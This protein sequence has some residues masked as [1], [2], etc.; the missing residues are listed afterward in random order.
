MHEGA[1]AA[2]RREGDEDGRTELTDARGDADGDARVR[3]W[4]RRAMLELA[5]GAPIRTRP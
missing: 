3:E 5:D 2:L 1:S 4:C